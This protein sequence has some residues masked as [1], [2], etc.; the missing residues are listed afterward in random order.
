MFCELCP[1]GAGRWPAFCTGSPFGCPA[2]HLPSQVSKDITVPYPEQQSKKSSARSDS[3]L[4]YLSYLQQTTKLHHITPK[5]TITQASCSVYVEIPCFYVVKFKKKIL[6]KWPEPE[7]TNVLSDV[8]CLLCVVNT[9][10]YLC[11]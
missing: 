3:L 8:F 10:T 1:C 7:E 11:Y 5:N 2:Q 6:K 9:G 4:W